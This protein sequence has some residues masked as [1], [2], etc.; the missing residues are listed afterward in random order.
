MDPQLQNVNNLDGSRRNSSTV[1]EKLKVNADEVE[2][3]TPSNSV[4]AVNYLN[5]SRAVKGDDS[6]GQ[7]A[8]NNKSRIAACSLMV[9]YVGKSFSISYTELY[10]V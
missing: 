4:D 1:L 7:I 10:A 9:V 6:D 5:N 8:W 2:N 3:A